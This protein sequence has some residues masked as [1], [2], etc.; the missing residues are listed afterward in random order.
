MQVAVPGRRFSRTPCLRRVQAVSSIS[1]YE[2]G[3]A[4]DRYKATTRQKTEENI[5]ASICFA[6]GYFFLA[7]EAENRS[8]VQTKGSV[9]SDLPVGRRGSHHFWFTDFVRLL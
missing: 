8:L 5:R 4:N 7:V 3:R 9:R 2:N 1:R 6:L